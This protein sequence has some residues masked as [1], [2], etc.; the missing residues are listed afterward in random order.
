MTNL[1]DDNT[2]W[3]CGVI[4]GQ[5]NTDANCQGTA[6]ART[7]SDLRRST[8]APSTSSR[9]PLRAISDRSFRFFS[10]LSSPTALQVL[11]VLDS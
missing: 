7:S 3:D 9:S 4:T 10:A 11:T 5:R 1:W 8:A 2:T 6:D